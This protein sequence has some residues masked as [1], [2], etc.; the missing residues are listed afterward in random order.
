MCTCKRCNRHVDAKETMACAVK[1]IKAWV[2]SL[3]S[4]ANLYRKVEELGLAERRLQSRLAEC[5]GIFRGKSSQNSSSVAGIRAKRVALRKTEDMLT[6]LA[7]RLGELAVA[8]GKEEALR[9]LVPA[10]SGR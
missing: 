3:P 2:H 8:A 5:E 10:G 7:A 9:A 1:P 4:S 6:A